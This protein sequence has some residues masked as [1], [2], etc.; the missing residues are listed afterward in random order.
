MPTI[1]LLR[2]LFC[3]SCLLVLVWGCAS[4]QT[5][6][7]T[8]ADAGEAASSLAETSR[9]DE[10]DGLEQGDL[11]AVV[12]NPQELEDWEIRVVEYRIDKNET[13]SDP[14]KTP[15]RAA[16]LPAFLEKG[17]LDYYIP[18][19]SLRFHVPF[20]AEASPDTID[21]VKRKGE[22]V[23]N[24]RKGSVR[25]LFE[26]ETYE[27][28]VFGPVDTTRHGDYLWLPFYDA[29]SGEATYPGGRYLD[30]ELEADGTVELDFNFAYNP[31][32]D[33]NHE[34]YN[35]TLPPEENRLP[36]KVEAGEQRFDLGE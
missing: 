21:L 32:C 5:E 31:L 22:T 29:T 24:L 2:V 10:D 4:D 11:G 6:D 7:S 18:E 8:D 19:R 34:K 36:F 27:L 15:L 3:L 25:F 13:F 14:A 30:L 16:D 35:C 12:M 9:T 23:A 17:G 26:G 33:Y 1:R 28:A 20:L